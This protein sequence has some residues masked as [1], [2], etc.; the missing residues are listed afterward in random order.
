MCLNL[1]KAFKPDGVSP[2]ILTECASENPF[3]IKELIKKSLILEKL[4]KS[5]FQ[6]IF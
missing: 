1:N 5:K 3:P 2:F 4:Q 6:S